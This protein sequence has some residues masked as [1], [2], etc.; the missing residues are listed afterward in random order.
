[1]TS[2]VHPLQS[3]KWLPNWAGRI[4]TIT[5]PPV[6]A[7]SQRPPFRGEGTLSATVMGKETIDGLSAGMKGD[8]GQPPVQVE[9]ATAVFSSTGTLSAGVSGPAVPQAMSHFDF[10]EGG[11]TQAHDLISG[12]TITAADPATAWHG[13]EAA[14]QFSGLVGAGNPAT[15][16]S[17]AF[18]CILN[19]V[20]PGLG[21]VE[22]SYDPLL[23]VQNAIAFSQAVEAYPGLFTPL[24][25]WVFSVIPFSTG[26]WH[27][28]VCVAGLGNTTLY[29]DGGISLVLG[30]LT[31]NDRWFNIKAV[32]LYAGNALD[33]YV[34]D[35]AYWDTAL[36]PK[37]AAAL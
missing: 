20:R 31:A 22:V 2:P 23:V 25:G 3:T 12:R 11:G 8:P 10:H 13:Q 36:T 29:V 27:N 18:R 9:R 16:W 28:V 19:S 1:M 32:L 5:P 26:R 14:G 34:D 4:P 30:P 21:V 35:L 24:T 37:E 17:V 6:G 33:A 15:T 7:R